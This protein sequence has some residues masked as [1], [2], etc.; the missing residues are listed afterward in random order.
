MSRGS[1]SFR[2]AVDGFK[3]SSQATK[4]AHATLDFDGAHLVAH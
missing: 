4:Q 3:E 2:S 1:P